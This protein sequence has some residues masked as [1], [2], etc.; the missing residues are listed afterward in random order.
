M[1]FVAIIIAAFCAFV[2]LAH[3]DLVKTTLFLMWVAMAAMAIGSIIHSL[4]PLLTK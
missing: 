1:I 2:G 3:P 4:A